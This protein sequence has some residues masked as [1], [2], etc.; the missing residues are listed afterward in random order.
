M[1]CHCNLE[2]ATLPNPG[3]AEVIRDLL[4]AN[5]EGHSVSLS[6]VFWEVETC[7]LYLLDSS[8]SPY[9]GVLSCFLYNWPGQDP[10]LDF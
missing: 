3:L 9:D 5:T 4:V 6:C 2:S 1:A 10:L 7:W 8:L